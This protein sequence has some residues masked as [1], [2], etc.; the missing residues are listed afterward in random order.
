MVNPWASHF[1]APQS[2]PA[3]AANF[4]MLTDPQEIDR[5]EYRPDIERAED[6]ENRLT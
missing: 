6:L 1:A 5:S 3:V 2:E 4:G